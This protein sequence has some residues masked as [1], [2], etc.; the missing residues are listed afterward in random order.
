MTLPMRVLVVVAI[1][2][3]LVAAADHAHA[4]SDAK[5]NEPKG[6]SAPVWMWLIPPVGLVVGIVLGAK[7]RARQLRQKPRE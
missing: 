5:T 3:T 2:F 7:L 6:E 4:A 1:A